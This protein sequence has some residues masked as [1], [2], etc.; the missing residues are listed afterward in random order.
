MI[1]VVPPSIAA[2]VPLSKSSAVDAKVIG[3]FESAYE[4]SINPGNT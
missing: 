1:E 2:F 4:G 3:H